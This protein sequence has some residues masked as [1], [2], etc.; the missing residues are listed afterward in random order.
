MLGLLKRINKG[1]ERLG[2]YWTSSISDPNASS[3]LNL[4]TSTESGEQVTPDLAMTLSAV[5]LAVDLYASAHKSMPVGIFKD[6]G[7]KK[8]YAIE[9]PAHKL[10]HVRPN[11]E[12]NAGVYWGLVEAHRL[13]WGVSFSEIEW[14]GRGE[15]KYIWPIEPW[16]VRVERV[17]D[18]EGR[19]RL[20]YHI[21]SDSDGL[22]GQRT[23]ESDDL[24][25]FPNFTKD[26]ITFKSAIEYGAETMGG[27]IAS[28]KLGNRWFA[29]DG[30]PQGFVKHPGKMEKPARDNFRREFKDGMK[31]SGNV[32]ILFEGMD[33]I[34]NQVNP[35]ALQLLGQKD[36]TITDIARFF[37]VQ[38]HKLMQLTKSSYST[39]EQGDLEWVK[40][41][42][43]PAIVDKEQEI[44]SKLVRYPDFYC[45]FS[46]EG[47]LRGDSKSR[48]AWYKTMRE[49]GAYSVND[50]LDYEDMDTIGANGDVRVVNAAYIPLD[51]VR[52][53]WEAK[54]K[55]K[56]LPQPGGGAMAGSGDA[57]DD[58]SQDGSKPGATPS[59]PPEPEPKLSAAEPTPRRLEDDPFFRAEL[60]RIQRR[61]AKALLRAAKNPHGF[62][63]WADTFLVKHQSFMLEVLRGPIVAFCLEN[64]HQGLPDEDF[65][66]SAYIDELKAGLLT[67]AEVPLPE[68]VASIRRFVEAR[69]DAVWFGDEGE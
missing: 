51:L 45:K 33:W 1:A 66:V 59:D 57:G 19:K 42:I 9:N 5:F 61:E 39:N 12:M 69:A 41:S 30:M 38:P 25:I 56:A 26:G 31:K 44:N 40:G 11:P 58:P 14:N 8:Q 46:V 64:K 15:P 3:F 49:I 37:K 32:G 27:G 4:G 52:K 48:A 20:V 16:R 2:R 65:D 28:Q 17:R 68:F 7:S 29:N 22:G 47:L 6:A 54:S 36:F 43:L 35:E 21:A 55:P 62:L 24:L 50:I 18:S 53:Y 23:L 67:A 34:A 10:I 63:D 60:S 13:L